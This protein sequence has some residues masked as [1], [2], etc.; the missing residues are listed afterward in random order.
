M[1]SS[2]VSLEIRHNTS[3][4]WIDNIIYFA[5]KATEPSNISVGLLG[6]FLWWWLHLSFWRSRSPDAGLIRP[7]GANVVEWKPHGNPWRCW[8]CY[9]PPFSLSLHSV[10]VS[11][12]P[13]PENRSYCNTKQERRNRK[14]NTSIILV[15]SFPTV[16]IGNLCVVPP[17]CVMR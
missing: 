8:P 11:L 2:M 16:A 15:N 9:F 12:E 6:Y 1:F 5:Y 14:G 17:P 4:L 3:V 7:L 10:I 13:L